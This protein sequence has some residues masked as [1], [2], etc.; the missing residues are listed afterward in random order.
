MIVSRPCAL[1]QTFAGSAL[2]RFLS[3]RRR[4]H[5]PTSSPKAKYAAPDRKGPKA[6]GHTCFVPSRAKPSCVTSTP[7]MPGASANLK[8]DHGNTED[9][10]RNWVQLSGVNFLL[11]PCGSRTTYLREDCAIV[12]RPVHR[13]LHRTAHHWSVFL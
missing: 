1:L 2:S 4:F 5:L 3:L 7:D 11:V 8:R 9:S 6:I 10:L 13:L 12:N